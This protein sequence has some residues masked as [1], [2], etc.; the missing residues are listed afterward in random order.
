MLYMPVHV[1]ICP[2]IRTSVLLHMI[3]V[4]PFACALW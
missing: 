4:L 2:L 1:L 3:I